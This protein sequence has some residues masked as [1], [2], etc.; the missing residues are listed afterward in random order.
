M[1]SESHAPRP[2]LLVAVDAPRGAWLE[3]LRAR[4]AACE[5]QLDPTDQI[6][7][8]SLAQNFVVRGVLRKTKDIGGR[9]HLI[10]LLSDG[11][12]ESSLAHLF[13]LVDLA[14]AASVR[15][16]VHALL[17]GVD[18]PAHSAAGYL[19]QLEQRL[20]GG[21]G[22]IG[23]VGGRAFGMDTTGRWDRIGKAYQAIVADGVTRA[24][25][26][27]AGVKEACAFGNP[28]T[29]V[30]PFVVF[31]YPG[32]SLVDSALVFNF[33]SDGARGLSQAL[34]S[35]DFRHFV[36]KG[37]KPPFGGRFATMVP[38]GELAGSP[39]LFPRA[40]D[41]L[42]LALDELEDAGVS[43]APCTRGPAAAIADEALEALRGASHGLVV[44]DFGDPENPERTPPGEQ[45]TRALEQLL[46]GARTLGCSAFV[47]GGRDAK[48]RV[49]LIDASRDA[50]PLRPELC[51]ADLGAM[52]RERLK[53]LLTSAAPG[54][55]RCKA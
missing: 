16:V 55:S 21:V 34:A 38:V 6:D 48:N 27:I 10:G 49:P 28:E 7:A 51:V 11:G 4:H 32:V 3:P 45:R 9:L 14:Q 31:D 2:A 13:A 50:S 1:H 12:A 52:L 18:V 26:A 37:G 17:D 46:E 41:P 30:E 39:T 35:K 53:G 15:V 36:R 42:S 33:G 25:S 5:L 44:A 20:A 54:T 19:A 22:R 29:F 40:A 24:D 47:L 43:I 23:T 8:A